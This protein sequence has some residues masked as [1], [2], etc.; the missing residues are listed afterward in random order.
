[1][2]E[3]E[4]SASAAGKQQGRRGL[5]MSYRRS[6]S[7]PWTGRLTADL[8]AHF[9][10][11]NVYLDLDSNLPAQDYID[12]IERWLH[13]ASVAVVVIGPTWA[14]GD[15]ARRLANP[16][17]LHRREVEIA[18]GSGATVMP[19]LVGGAMMPGAGAVP[20]A[21]APILRIQAHRISD[22]D[23]EYGLGRLLDTLEV[24]GVRPS[25]EPETTQETD[26]DLSALKRYSRTVKASRRRTLDAVT[27]AVDQLGYG[28]VKVS[29]ERAQVTFASMM[30]TVSVNVVDAGSGKSTVV[31]SFRTVHGGVVGGA[32]V[33]AVV[34]TGGALIIPA[35]AAYPAL[36]LWERRFSKKFLDDVET[37]LDGRPVGTEKR[38]RTTEI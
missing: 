11:S 37:V 21:L 22:D 5:F 8:R 18:L 23:W 31:V 38:D 36:R 24:R 20:E 13:H 35:A 4:A 15:H 34:A 29:V 27:N 32:G 3:K 33:A 25:R 1:M 17:D 2:A 30:R 19:V 26:V 12:K 7:G 16:A 9:G 28:E 14:D 10:Q 6:D